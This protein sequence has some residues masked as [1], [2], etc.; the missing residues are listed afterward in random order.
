VK[1]ILLGPAMFIALMLASCTGGNMAETVPVPGKINSISREKME[2]IANCRIFFGHQSVGFNILD[3]VREISA[4]N[5]TPLFRIIESRDLPSAPV[6]GFFHATIGRNT[7]PISKIRDFEQI[8]RH[9]KGIDIAFMKFCYLD[10]D[11]GTD[12]EAVFRAYRAA[13][14]K[15]KTDF[16]DTTFVH[17]TVPITSPEKGIKAALKRLLGRSVRGDGD[18]MAKERFNKLIRSEYGHREPL[19]DLAYFESTSEN[20]LRIANAIRGDKYYTLRDEYTTDGGHLNKEG[21]RYIAGQLLIFLT[22]LTE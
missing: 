18:N 16:P 6:A 8:V 10:V 3:G 21:R 13:F 20:G 2:L 9:G 11:E 15:L 4:Q 19:F 14:A 12:V 17:L 22:S 5:G 1:T 7:D